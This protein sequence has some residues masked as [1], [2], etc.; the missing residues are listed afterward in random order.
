MRGAPRTVPASESAYVD[1]A[2]LLGRIGGGRLPG[3]RVLTLLADIESSATVGVLLI[4][5]LKDGDDPDTTP[6]TSCATSPSR[7]RG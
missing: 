5:Q 7:C 6:A 3:K 2:S 4:S 1:D